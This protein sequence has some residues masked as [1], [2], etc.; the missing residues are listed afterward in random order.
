MILNTFWYTV[1]YFGAMMPIWKQKRDGENRM[2]RGLQREGEGEWWL[3]LYMKYSGG[4]NGE[5]H[6]MKT[7]YL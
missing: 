5:F 4:V 3:I 7:P 1:V 6:A 2:E